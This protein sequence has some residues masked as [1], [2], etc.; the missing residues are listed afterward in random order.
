MYVQITTRCNMSC[1]HCCN[2]DTAPE[3]MSF[4]T[5]SLALD[6]WFKP[7]TKVVIGGGEPTIHPEFWKI[8]SY[9][10]S[11][12]IPWLATNGAKTEDALVL[13]GLAKRGKCAVSLSLDEWH[14]PI[15]QRV[16]SA[17]E[18]K[19]KRT[20]A[21]KDGEIIYSREK[22]DL[23]S[24]KTCKIP[25]ARG[26]LKGTDGLVLGCCKYVRIKPDGSIRLCSCDDS[27]VMGTVEHG[28]SEKFLS[29]PMH[30]EMGKLCYTD[31]EVLTSGHYVVQPK[32]NRLDITR[33]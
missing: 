9:S 13:A 22:N 16:I 25:V 14:S 32:Y 19:N 3:D 1:A 23:R 11:I 28:I 15:D 12:G 7:G 20:R 5:F 31:Y 24:I 6:R 33:K 18:I 17:F 2:F 8:L 30:N 4:E 26:K 21:G 27:P 29:V 10:M